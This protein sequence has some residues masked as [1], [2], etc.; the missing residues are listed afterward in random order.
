MNSCI[1]N[2]VVKH[3]RFK[4]IKHSLNY[5]TFSL[6]VDLD[7]IQSLAKN[8][9]I[10]S[11]NKLQNLK[12]N[13]DY[14]L[15]LNPVEN[16]IRNKIIKKVIYTHPYF[17][18]ENVILQKDLYSLQGKKRTWFCGSYFGYGFHED[19]LKSSIELIKSFD[20]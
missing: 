17:N 12:T 13:K 15:T 4:P 8:I 10:F 20:T 1:Y 19:G 11:L 7:E 3:Q 16:I 18:K 5:K 6:L 9:S 14:F 2:G